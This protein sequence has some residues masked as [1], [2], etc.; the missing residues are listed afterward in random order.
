M[1]LLY[2]DHSGELYNAAERYFVMGGVAV[3]ERQIYHLGQDLEEIQQTILPRVTGRVEFHASPIRS[4]H[5]PPWKGMSW[6]EREQIMAGVYDAVAK[7]HSSVCLFGQ[8]IEKSHVVPDFD[9]L[10]GGALERKKEAEERLNKARGEERREARRELSD[11]NKQCWSLASTIV[12]RGFR[13]L[14]TQFEFFLR[15]FYDATQPELQQRGLMIFD[16]AS[17]ERELEFLMEEF[18][19]YGTGALAQI[20][21]VTEV[22]L[23]TRSDATR[24]LQI[25]DFVS[26][27]IFRRY[28][29]R[30][31]SYF[32]RVAHRFD[33]DDRVVHGLAHRSSGASTCMCPACLTRRL[34]RGGA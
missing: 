1:Y 11:A 15:R 23:F 7:A 14:C 10:M 22:P 12:A 24:M 5:K 4:G 13:G 19:S 3:F 2:I 26:F 16:H 28:E 18:R 20:Y 25:A 27:C 30:D 29:F 34:R 8:A 17:Y 21:N 33:Q 32:D 31:S 9:T 6:Q